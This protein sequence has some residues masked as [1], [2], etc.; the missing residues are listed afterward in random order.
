MT[1]AQQA[2]RAGLASLAEVAKLTGVGTSTLHLW[3]KNKPALYAVV[4]EGC[5]AVKLRQI[6][7]RRHEAEHERL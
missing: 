1:P 4:L 2:K 7:E 5:M 3:Y 6:E